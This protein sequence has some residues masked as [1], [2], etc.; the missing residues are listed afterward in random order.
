MSRVHFPTEAK[1]ERVPLVDRDQLI[2]LGQIL[3]EHF[4]NM[5][6]AR[7]ERIASAKSAETDRVRK[8]FKDWPEER[9]QE[10]LDAVHTS[11]ESGYEFRNA[12]PTFH[13]RMA[14]G[15]SHEYSSVR[16]MLD[17]PQVT[18]ELPTGLTA[19]LKCAEV[20]AK[21]VI[22]GGWFTGIDISVSPPTSQP[23]ALL[24]RSLER[25]ADNVCLPQ[26]SRWWRASRFYVPA[27]AF[28]LLLVISFVIIRE[29]HT[30]NPEAALHQRLIVGEAKELLDVGISEDNRDRALELLLAKTAGVALP[31]AVTDPSATHK[32][33]VFGWH[34]IVLIAYVCFLVVVAYRPPRMAVAVGRGEARVIRQ[35][36]WV[37]WVTRVAV[38]G[39]FVNV[40]YAVIA[41]AFTTSVGV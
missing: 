2:E 24:L 16:E 6:E 19:W 27:F 34:S 8:E 36:H 22:Q 12:S 25:W 3:D 41:S 17:D 14:S 1:V 21:L 40:A 11:I 38:G 37:W 31:H 18:N 32:T 4:E 29:H 20:E 35:R 10:Y 26:Y 39:L 15:K 9:I 33:V 23:A 13:V 28:F 7:S 5:K 30:I